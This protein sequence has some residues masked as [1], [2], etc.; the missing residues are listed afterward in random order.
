M[1]RPIVEAS[2]P[3]HR[4]PQG[5]RGKRQGEHVPGDRVGDEGDRQGFH[6]TPPFVIELVDPAVMVSDKSD[7]AHL[8]S[9][10]ACFKCIDFTIQ[11]TA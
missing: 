10:G 4:G 3:I 7:S 5:G 6:F 1:C 2:L 8:A 11:C 9:N